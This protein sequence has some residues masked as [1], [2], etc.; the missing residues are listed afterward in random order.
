MRLFCKEAERC[1]KYPQNDG[2]T[3]VV[4]DLMAGTALVVLV[5][6]VLAVAVFEITVWRECIAAEPWWYCLRV[7]GK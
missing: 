3:Q 1:G 4:R 2:E 6:L 7:L 5:A